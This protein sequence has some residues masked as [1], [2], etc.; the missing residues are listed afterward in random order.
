VKV[1]VVGG[2]KVGFYLVRT[3]LEKRH[4]VAVVEVDAQRA[5]R[6]ASQLPGVL[7]IAGN[8]TK[9]TDLSDAGA[10]TADVLAAVTGLDEVNLVT[11][12]VAKREFDI[13]KTIARV[14][15]PKNQAILHELGVDAAVSSTATIAHLVERE[16]HL[17][18]L[19]Q[20]LVLQQGRMALVETR[21]DPNAAAMGTLVRDLAPSLPADSVLV[22]VLRGDRVIFPRGDTRLSVGDT[23]LALTLTEQEAALTRALKG[24]GWAGVVR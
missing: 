22:A 11:C 24:E 9:M 14:N 18:G 10:D 20:L 23:V 1:V 6:L 12:Q 16:T 7:V 8:G 19:R 21:I 13:R 5:Q 3:L 17:D 2:G 4:E 15:N